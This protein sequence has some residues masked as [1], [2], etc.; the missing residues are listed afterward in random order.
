M[1]WEISHRIS[2]AFPQGEM[3]MIDRFPYGLKSRRLFLFPT[4]FGVIVTLEFESGD[5]GVGVF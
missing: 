4:S 5:S 2:T 3:K 1:A